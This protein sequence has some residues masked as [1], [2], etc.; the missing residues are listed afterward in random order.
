MVRIVSVLRNK[1]GCTQYP[2]SGS[3]YRAHVLIA[4][5]FLAEGPG[6]ANL[7]MQY[8]MKTFTSRKQDTVC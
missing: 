6:Y 8:T 5:I 2:R 1:R 7:K 3:A 4:A